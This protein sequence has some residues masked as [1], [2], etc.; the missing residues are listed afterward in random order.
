MESIPTQ[1]IAII[2][3]CVWMAKLEDDHAREMVILTGSAH[4][5]ANTEN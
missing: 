1:P 5:V 3:T 4:P 2:T